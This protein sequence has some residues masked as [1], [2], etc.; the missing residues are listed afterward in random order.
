MMWRPTKGIT[1]V[2]SQ[3]G[4][5]THQPRTLSPPWLNFNRGGQG[6]LPYPERSRC[7]G[8]ARRTDHTH[9]FGDKTREREREKIQT[10]RGVSLAD[11]TG[12]TNQLNLL[13][14]YIRE[15]EED[16]TASNT[17][18]NRCCRADEDVY[19][20]QYALIIGLT[21]KRDRQ[22]TDMENR[23]NALREVRELLHKVGSQSDD[24]DDLTQYSSGLELD[25]RWMV[26]YWAEGLYLQRDVDGQPDTLFI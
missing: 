1:A 3:N 19:I 17:I 11:M 5:Q 20:T 14:P 13:R 4:R 8:K 25:T 26:K 23:E 21:P 6:K 15:M 9:S 18:E 16:I 12:A 24:P 10:F 2:P 22:L 7:E